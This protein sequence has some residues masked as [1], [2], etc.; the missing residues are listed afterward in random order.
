LRFR[1]IGDS[2]VM[3]A[4]LEDAMSTIRVSTAHVLAVVIPAV[5]LVA[6]QNSPTAPS[7]TIATTGA[8]AS[9]S[10]VSTAG[11]ALAAATA[12]EQASDTQ[13]ASN[14]VISNTR[15]PF[16]G[17]GL[18]P[19][20]QETVQ[21]EGVLHVI[22][23]Q[24]TDAA[25]GTHYLLTHNW[26]QLGQVGQTTGAITHDHSNRH[27]VEATPGASGVA[28]STFVWTIGFTG[29]GQTPNYLLHIVAHTTVS[30]DGSVATNFERIWITCR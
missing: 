16:G 27:I 10:S 9:V 5:L 26:D 8:A 1:F 17:E 13:F 4:R 28:V 23:A 19:C 14:S 6:C 11:T 24:T 25:G 15:N 22:V 18:N 29:V 2:F 7:S 20:T 3:L 30:P 21:F 12:Q